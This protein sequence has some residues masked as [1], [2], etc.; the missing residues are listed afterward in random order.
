MK[1]KGLLVSD[2]SLQVKLAKYVSKQVLFKSG[3]DKF[4]ISARG[5]FFFSLKMNYDG[6]EEDYIM[7]K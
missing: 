3:R 7:Q 1:Q 5:M 6:T 4:H 2:A